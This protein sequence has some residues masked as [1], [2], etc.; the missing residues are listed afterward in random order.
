MEEIFQTIDPTHLSLR[1]WEQQFPTLRV[2]CTTRKNDF[3]FQS[4]DPKD[5]ERIFQLF[6]D[7]LRLP[8]SYG[9]IGEQIHASNIQ[10]VT[11]AN[12]DPEVKGQSMSQM[13]GLITMEKNIILLK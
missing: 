4:D 13:D 10:F 2:G 1:H 3:S 9:F 5:V 6:T 12:I 8:A 11:A 7:T